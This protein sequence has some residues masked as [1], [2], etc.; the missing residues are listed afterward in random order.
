MFMTFLTTQQI[1]IWA[2]LMKRYLYYA[3][4]SLLLASCGGGGGDG[5]SDSGA[6]S[7]KKGKAC[8]TTTIANG[9]GEFPWDKK[10]KKHSHNLQS[11]LL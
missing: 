8:P 7:K 9:K 5:G 2:D 1:N 6:S 11:R 10:A 3:F 4:L